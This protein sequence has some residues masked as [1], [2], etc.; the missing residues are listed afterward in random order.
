MGL[1]HW[2][3]LP[4]RKR[5]LTTGMLSCGGMIILQEGQCEPGERPIL[6]L[7]YGEDAHIGETAEG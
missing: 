3:H 1:S 7:G 4:L 2:R 6:F 5:K